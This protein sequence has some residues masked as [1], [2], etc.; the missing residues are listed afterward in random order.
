MPADLLLERALGAG[1]LLPRAAVGPAATPTPCSCRSRSTEQVPGSVQ[2]GS[3]VDVYLV[4]S[5]RP[6][7]RRGAGPVLVAAPSST[8]PPGRLRGRGVQQLVLAV[9]AR[10]RAASSPCSASR[11][12]L[13]TVVRRAAE[14][15]PTASCARGRGGL[16]APGP[17]PARRAPRLVVL[18][19]CV[20]VDDLLAAAAAG[21]A[22]VAVLGSTPPA[23]TPPPSTTCAGTASARSRWPR[24]ARRCP[25][26][27]HADRHPAL[28]AD[29]DLARCPTPWPR[30]V[31]AHRGLGCHS[32][33]G[34][35][36]PAVRAS[37]EPGPGRVVAVWGPAGAPVVPPSRRRSPP[38]SPVAAGAPSWSTPT[39]TAAPWP[40][41]SAS[42]TRS[43]ACWPPPAGHRR[44]ARA[45]VRLR[46]A[47]HG[48]PA[49]RWSRVFREPT[50]GSRSV[51]ARSST[52]LEVARERRGRGRHGL[53]P[54]G[55]P[56]RRP[57]LPARP[58]P[59]D[60]GRPR[61]GRRAGRGRHRRP[62]RALA[63]WPGALVELRDLVAGRPC[64][65]WSTGCAP[66]WAG[67]SATSRHGG[68][69][70]PSPACTSCPR[71][72]PA[73]T[74]RWSPGGRSRGG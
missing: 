9:P 71:T 8:H 25:G 12:P 60:P 45:A 55:R 3:V 35:A 11:G 43:P 66:P 40:S 18:K 56:P 38:S 39:P 20:D 24:G 2:P 57:R 22:D 15:W 72:G 19:R 42:S 27:G 61:R 48:R 7:A 13:L 4:A 41:S 37:S 62:G 30:R 50:A 53:Q 33:R 36:P 44:R 52:L 6:F 28:V 5:R 26:A 64:T 51:R 54:R 73:S 32:A 49:L 23:S 58:Q 10:T 68:G 16:G 14:P 65:S 17:R 31:S 63:G 59:A 69:L 29:D 21:Q 67:P 1:E 74:G 46:A 47:R 34:L 70:R